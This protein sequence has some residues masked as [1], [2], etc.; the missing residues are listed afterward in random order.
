[1]TALR[2]ALLAAGTALLL[3]LTTAVPA[4]AA[5]GDL[6]LQA[7]DATTLSPATRRALDANR[8]PYASPTPSARSA[9][10]LAGPAGLADE[11]DLKA[12]CAGHLSE[13]GATRK[14]W[15]RDRFQQCLAKKRTGGV[16][17]HDGNGVPAGELRFDLW[18]LGIASNNSRAVRYTIIVEEI[19][20]STMPGTVID[21]PN[22]HI[23]FDW[24]G[25]DLADCV[26]AAQDRTVDQWFNDPDHT[27]TL[28]TPDKSG[29]PP[30][31]LVNGLMYLDMKLG[32]LPI[33]P[34][35]FFEVFETKFRFDSA[36]AQSPANGAVFPEVVPT[37]ALALSDPGVDQSARHISDAW[38]RPQYTFPSWVGKT[39]PGRDDELHRLADDTDNRLNREKSIA[40]CKD[41]WGD[42]SENLLQCDEFP[43]ASTKEGSFTGPRD[44]GSTAQRFSARLIDGADN[45]RAGGRLG[46]FYTGNRL[47]DG[48]PFRMRIDP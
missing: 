10:G 48:D 23:A 35:P 2:R 20:V 18:V 26:A 5:T 3:T 14:G 28:T 46:A 4:H 22:Q 31:Y 33:R 29:P 30:D 24:R 45:V 21:W 15:L 37:F 36:R 43:F 19:T 7:G 40:V 47:V 11:A 12:A 17:V 13:A 8:R 39:V 42:Y 27:F 32:S 38:N 6:R 41:V 16:V 25:C 44:S 1:M 34:T 9:A